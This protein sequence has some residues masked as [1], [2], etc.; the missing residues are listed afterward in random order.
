MKDQSLDGRIDG[1]QAGMG[2]SSK[3]QGLNQYEWR[4]YYCAFE[5]AD[6]GGHDEVIIFK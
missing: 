6:D 5:G 3:M 2:S 1:G 4:V